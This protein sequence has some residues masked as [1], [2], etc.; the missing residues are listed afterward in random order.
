MK[1]KWP[2][3]DILKLYSGTYTKNDNVYCDASWEDTVVNTHDDKARFLAHKKWN[4]WLSLCLKTKNLNE[5][6]AMRYGLQAGMDDLAKK[7]MATPEIVDMWIR[8]CRSI[9]KTATKIIVL[10]NPI[11][12]DGDQQKV[13]LAKKQRNAEIEKFFMESAF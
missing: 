8:W 3:I 6:M 4:E 9:E 2:T 13:A 11:S 12:V 1:R 10:K 7:N 5:L